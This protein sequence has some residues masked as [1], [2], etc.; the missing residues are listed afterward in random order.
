MYL[1]GQLNRKSFKFF[2]RLAFIAIMK[3]L[4]I[5]IKAQNKTYN[6]TIKNYGVAS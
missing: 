1:R 2:N 3:H 6:V 4:M 5:Y